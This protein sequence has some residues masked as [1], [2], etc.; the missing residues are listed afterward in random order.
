MMKPKILLCP[1]VTD[2]YPRAERAIRSAFM[3]KFHDLEFGV[4]VVINSQNLIF[5]H[6]IKNYCEYH[7]IPYS[8]T[9]SDG[10]PSTGKNA[11]FDVFKNSD[12]THM[13]Q[14]DGD[15]IFYP[16]FLTQTQRHLKK[17]PSTDVLATIPLDIMV[18]NF[19]KDEIRLKNGEYALFWG[20]HYASPENWN[21]YFGRDVIVDGKSIP[22]YARFVLYSKKIVEMGYRYDKEFIVGE[23]KKLHFDFL[24][25]HQKDEISYW[26]TMASDMWVCD[27]NSF[28]VQKQHTSGGEI[29]FDDVETTERLRKYVV[30]ILNEDRSAPGEI[31][32]DYPPMYLYPHQKEQFLNDI[33]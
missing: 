17:Y 33:L 10:T 28:G 9:E 26:F 5:I 32:T 12:Y 25:A 8:V 7:K 23:D 30:S 11:V 4:H 24:L 31:P 6:K 21:G 29:I 14:L 20:T 16:T 27:R 18:S 13:S 3:Q 19:E 15:D 22:N 2:D 1:L